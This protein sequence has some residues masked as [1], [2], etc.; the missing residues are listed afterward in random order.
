VVIR[1]NCRRLVE[2]EDLS[3]GFAVLTVLVRSS[4]SNSHQF[5][6]LSK[7]QTNCWV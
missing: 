4:T 7:G 1:G 6:N 2:V 3:R 5:V